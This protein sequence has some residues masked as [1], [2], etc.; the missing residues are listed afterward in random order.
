MAIYNWYLCEKLSHDFKI[1]NGVFSQVKNSY[2]CK[3]KAF[4]LF[5]S[6]KTISYK[7]ITLSKCL[8]SKRRIVEIQKLGR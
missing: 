4:G 3:L 1:T 5:V 8:K 7:V 6:D 2:K